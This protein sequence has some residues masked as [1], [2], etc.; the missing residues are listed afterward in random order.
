MP[1]FLADIPDAQGPETIMNS[2]VQ[3]T[4]QHLNISVA[5]IGTLVSSMAIEV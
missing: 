5:T 1:K 3:M 2:N 4:P